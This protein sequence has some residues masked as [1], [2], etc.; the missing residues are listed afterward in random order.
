MF[1]LIEHVPSQEELLAL[2]EA[3]GWRAYTVDPEGLHRGV[4]NSTYVVAA[5]EEGELVGLA[6]VVSD[7]HSIMYLQDILV[8][9]SHQRRGIGRALL[10]R[11]LERF[12]HCRGKVLL[13]DDEERQI[14]FYESLGY[15]QAADVPHL[16]AFVWGQ[17]G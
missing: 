2:Y 4:T 13:T 15:V 10:E 12:A 16:T 6:R 14:C 11:C 17:D 7:D 1:E 8:L 5:R 9:P 3:N